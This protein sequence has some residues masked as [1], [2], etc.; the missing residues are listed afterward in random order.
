MM[1]LPIY[2]TGKGS[3]MRVRELASRELAP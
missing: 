2:A 3:N 1:D